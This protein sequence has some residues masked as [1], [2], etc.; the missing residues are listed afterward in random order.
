MP[1]DIGPR[2]GPPMIGLGP[3]MIGLGPES[4]DGGSARYVQ[5]LTPQ[6]LMY[7]VDPTAEVREAAA[8]ARE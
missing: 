3:L 7:A 4:G 5:A 2:I 1:I 8:V 6:L